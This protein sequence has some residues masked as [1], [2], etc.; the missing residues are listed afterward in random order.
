VT[1]PAVKPPTG[2]PAIPGDATPPPVSGTLS[3]AQ[4][5]A[6]K[7]SVSAFWAALG[8]SDVAAAVQTVPPAQRSCVRSLLTAGPKITVA[9]VTI[10]S[11][12]PAGNGK[13]TVRF[14]VQAHATIGGTSVPVLAPGPGSQQWLVTTEEAG[15]WYVDLASSNDFA[16]SGACP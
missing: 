3:A 16:F 5:A 2:T 13:A 8:A 6:A 15:H 7:Q 11:A 14:T 10:V 4:A 12:Q 1:P 9:S